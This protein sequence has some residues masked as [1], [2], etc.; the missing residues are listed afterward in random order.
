MRLR[1]DSLAYGGDAVARAEDG[2]VVFVRYGCPGDVVEVESLEEHNRH[3]VA[4][5]REVV[6]PS[7]QR[8]KPPCPYFG[9]CGGC[10]WQHIAYPTQLAAKR[11]SVLDA[12]VRIGGIAEPVVADTLPSPAEYGYRNRIELTVTDTPTGL[13]LGY[14]ELH[15]DQILPV[16]V[17][18]LPPK[19]LQ[20]APKALAGGL[21]YLSGRGEVELARVSLRSAARYSDVAVDLWGPPSGFPRQMA[22]KVLRDAVR[23]SSITRVLFKGPLKERRVSKVEVLSGRGFWRER[24]GEESYVVS[25]PSFFQVNTAVAERLVALA[26]DELECDGTDRVLDLYAGVGTFTLPLANLAEEVVAVEGSSSAIGDLRRNLEEAQ[27]YAEVVGGDAARELPD[28]GHFDKALIDPPR[29]GLQPA[30]L[31]ALVAAGPSRIVY[32]SCDPATLARDARRLLDAG[33][34][35]R[36]ATPVDMFPQTYHVETV[37]LF[38]R[39]RIES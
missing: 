31:D 38:E 9:R 1:V 36:R 20:K 18:L 28:L 13:R 32:V 3:I 10:Q 23:A 30:A 39:E 14:A 26:L 11:Q 2:R 15:S 37:A 12:L 4:T 29:G 19:R 35:L 21:R 17:C 25:A 33:Y 7:P 8:V 24:L 34:S 6:E 27:L 22:A 5:I 16:D